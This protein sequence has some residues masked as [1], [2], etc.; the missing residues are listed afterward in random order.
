MRKIY[1]LFFIAF[2]IAVKAQTV[3]PSLESWTTKTNQIHVQGTAN[4]S[5][6]SVDYEIDDPQFTYND[7][8]HWSSLNQLT[9]TESVVYPATN[10]PDV[11]LVTQSTD[12]VD[13]TFSTRLESKTIKIKVTATA[14]GFTFD[15]SVTNVAPGMM[16]SGVFNLDVNAFA[17][18][19]V[20]S[21]SLSSLDPFSYNGT[22]QPIDFRPGTLSGMYKYDGL[23]G[24]SAL[25][26]TGAIKNRV[27][28]AYAIKRLPSTSIWTSFDVDLEYSS[29]D[30]PDT[31][32]TLFC[33]SNLDASFTG[34]NFSVNSNYT[35]VDGSV[36]FVDNLSLDTL[37]ASVFPPSAVN[38]NSTISNVET[39]T[40]DVTLNDVNCDPSGN[41]PVIITSGQNGTATNGSGNELDY[42]PNSGFVGTDVVTYY[43]CNSGGACDT[44][45]WFIEV[46]APPLCEA[47]NDNRTLD[48]N[49]TSTFDPLANDDNCFT[50][51]AII[52]LPLNGTASVVSGEISYSPVNNFIGV[53]SLTY[54]V[55]NDIDPTQCSTAK[56]Y[57]Q[58]LTGIKEIPSSSIVVAPNP[59]K[60]KVSISLKNINESTTVSIYNMLGKKVY[61]AQFMQTTE[62]N[63]SKF[64]TGVYLIQ[65]EN[66]KGKATKK[67]IVSK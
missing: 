31:I 40:L 5:G 41:A 28:V 27:V 66:Q 1:I 59:A 58:V 61:Q 26:V 7:L 13:G 15:T 11:E 46:T 19:L 54:Q 55:C 43:I 23:S 29:C 62:I 57:Y 30:M 4:I 51:L 8:T 44:A 49:T 24:D 60:D 63:L 53:D 3:D 17:D 47:Y 34:G 20:N 48:Q 38:D 22:G 25:V 6:M 10:D 50:N 56:V 65:L 52:V 67:L 39:A 21:T 33:S 45:S 37:D 35:G 64:N 18:Q 16:V 2:A 12:A 14:F 36:L 32:V 42:T 9:K